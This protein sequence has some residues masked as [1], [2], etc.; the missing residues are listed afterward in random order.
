[1]RVLAAVV[2][3]VVCIIAG[4]MMWGS[5][6]AQAWLAASFVIAAMIVLAGRG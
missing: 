6:G 2:Y 5:E 1:M 3:Q 4:V